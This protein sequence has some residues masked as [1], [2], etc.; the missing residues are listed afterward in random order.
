MSYNNQLSSEEIELKNEE[1]ENY[2]ANTIIPQLFVDAQF[3]LRKFTPPTMTHFN[4]SESDLGKDFDLVKD[5]IKH[6]TVMEN[7]Q[8]VIETGEILEKEIQTTDGRWY[9]MNILPYVVRKENRTN[10]VILTFVEITQRIQTKR[11]LEKLNAEHDTLMYALS[12]D[13]RQPLS[14]LSLLG[15]VLE[16]SYEARDRGK[17]DQTMKQLR[18]SVDSVRSLVESFLVANGS[19][20]AMEKKVEKIDLRKM[21]ENIATGLKTE[22]FNTDNF[23]YDFEVSEIQFSRNNLRSILYNLLNNA[24]KY[25][26]PDRELQVELSTRKVDGF[27]LLTVKDNGMGIALEDQAKIFEKGGRLNS[28]LEGTGMGLYIIKRMLESMG[29]TISVESKPGKGSAFLVYFSNT[30]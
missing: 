14:V 23:T 19:D 15:T 21:V 27:T 18:Q 17:F 26:K 11:E 10:G 25:R 7:I 8:E 22:I 9:Q 20:P 5:N 6:P 3:I 24:I 16:H 4:L 30:P 1:L 2:F 12:H 29:G 28:E 13:I